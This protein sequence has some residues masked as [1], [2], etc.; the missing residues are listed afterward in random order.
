[1][2]NI[3]FI[4]SLLFVTVV[5]AQL[6]EVPRGKINVIAKDV[7]VKIDSL[8]LLP[9]KDTITVPPEVGAIQISSNDSLP[10][11]YDGESWKR[12]F[13]KHIV[14]TTEDLNNIPRRDRQIGM[15]V[16]N[17]ETK[18]FYVLDD[19][20][21]NSNWTALDYVKQCDL[22]VIINGLDDTYVTKYSDQDDLTGK[23]TWANTQTFL[24]S[25]L[26]YN[27]YI[28]GGGSNIAFGATTDGILMANSG[29]EN[30]K[31][32]WT[33]GIFKIQ[34]TDGAG[35][36]RNLILQS[37]G[38]SDGTGGTRILLNNAGM[39]NTNTNPQMQFDVNS[40]LGNPDGVIQFTTTYSNSSGG[41]NFVNIKPTIAG[42]GSSSYNLFDINPTITSTGSGV[43]T[44]QRWRVSGLTKS[45][46]RTD[47]VH[48][49]GGNYG[50]LFN[51]S[52]LV[53]KNYVDS[54]VATAGGGAASRFGVVGEDDHSGT[55]IDEFERIFDMS[56][57]TFDIHHAERFKVDARTTGVNSN[58][59]YMSVESGAARLH[60]DNSES[61]PPGT[62]D[63]NL[64]V[65][66]E[67]IQIEAIDDSLV[68]S[69][70]N[71]EIHI[72]EQN[73][74]ISVT[75]GADSVASPPRGIYGYDIDGFLKKYSYAGGI[76]S[77]N[78]LTA[79][80]QT[81]AT[82]T[83]GSD[84][85]ISS[86]T[87][88][89]T[90]NI[91]DAGP[92]T[93]GFVSTGT[94]TL[95][96]SKSFSSAVTNFNTTS[97]VIRT[98][99]GGSNITPVTFVDI[100]GSAST[101]G[102]LGV[103]IDNTTGLLGF[104]HAN[105]TR[106]ILGAGIGLI[107][108]TNTAGSEASDLAFHT[109]SGGTALTEKFRIGSAG[110]WY[111]NT[112]AGTANQIIGVNSGGTAMEWK[113]LPTGTVSN[114]TGTSPII[115][116]TGT[117]TPVVSLAGLTGLGTGNQLIGMN[118]GAT[119]WEYKSNIL[120]TGSASFGSLA[121]TAGDADINGNV[122]I[123]DGNKLFLKSTAANQVTLE[124]L[125]TS[126][127]AITVPEADGEMVVN[128]ATQTLT[129]KS[130][131][132][133][134]LTGTL[135]AG[136]F[137]ALTGDVTT[138]AG[139]LATT[140]ASGAVTYAKMQTFGAYKFIANNTGSTATPT[141]ITFRDN[142]TQTY[143]G[144]LAWSGTPPSGTLN[145]T[146]HWVQIGN[147]V[148]LTITLN[149]TVAGTTNTTVTM[150]LPSD[151]PSPANPTGTGAANTKV[152]NGFGYI[153][154]ALTGNPPATRAILAENA[155]ANGWLLSA[156]AASQSAL[157]AQVTVIYYTN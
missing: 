81:F 53:D 154:A 112:T 107:N 79:G 95:A 58:N 96:G 47:G 106:R 146:Y 97:G 34:V 27:I 121:V 22:E 70:D 71:G 32:D 92:S 14:N 9:L 126:N 87:S 65:G 122:I 116:A 38:S 98:T 134:Q 150:T 82:G 50:S 6:P 30:A 7:N 33:D 20:Y 109:Q 66:S 28:E 128:S 36:S 2:K 37:L 17:I 117:T 68:L 111:L 46:V 140:I 142:G 74:A 11:Y 31:L 99:N 135:Q 102:T 18:Q 88:T 91:P 23:K 40:P 151:C 147:M 64:W 72:N 5:H 101:A 69:A 86:V 51:D 89:H 85:N 44:L 52:S 42:T 19:G 83:S 141:E 152:Y 119:S 39:G 94:Q 143:A 80:T 137:P 156:V 41:R 77:L 131:V 130:I 136:Q 55:G 49:Y 13:N 132:A 4:L 115:V 149:Y 67:G 26:G 129:N 59:T 43:S 139:S 3:L 104:T 114:V 25:L 8:L 10:Y 21:Q 144:T 24:D 57:A 133:T 118:T 12:L 124:Y 61:T 75:L 56:N 155:A 120:L 15:T 125:G 153:D 113:T 45:F 78:T 62:I 76:T 84:F 145:Q 123:Q 60:Y 16:Y 105:G 35:I 100:G 73:N 48:Q 93:R 103:S 54:S 108:L 29:G 90:F 138:S 110:L 157:V 127:H 63:N 1:M 148:T